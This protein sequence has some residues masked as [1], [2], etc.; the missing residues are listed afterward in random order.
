M[1]DKISTRTNGY[2]LAAGDYGIQDEPE[3]FYESIEKEL[4]THA[5]RLI[6]STVYES[7]GTPS[8]VNQD[9]RQKKKL[10]VS[11]LLVTIMNKRANIR[12]YLTEMK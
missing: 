4:N 10:L 1:I 11:R 5:M 8:P 3:K 6:K 9:I 12:L 2:S 7:G